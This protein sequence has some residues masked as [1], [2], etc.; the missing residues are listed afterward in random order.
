M[1]PAQ[2]A[3]AGAP[4]SILA[5]ICG[6]KIRCVGFRLKTARR[7]A[8]LA[9]PQADAGRNGQPLRRLRALDLESEHGLGWVMAEMVSRVSG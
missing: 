9:I 1:S 8:S 2:R 4:I 3:P 5:A 6:V 7:G